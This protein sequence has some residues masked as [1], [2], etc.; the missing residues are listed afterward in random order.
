MLTTNSKVKGIFDNLTYD[1][2]RK[3]SYLDIC[4]SDIDI[5]ILDGCNSPLKRYRKIY[6]DKRTRLECVLRRWCNED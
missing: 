6:K 2:W 4:D 1:V 5:F 3:K